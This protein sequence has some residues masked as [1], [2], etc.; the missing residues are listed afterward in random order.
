MG[1]AVQERGTP[2]V[3]QTKQ[4]SPPVPTEQEHLYPISGM[5]TQKHSLHH[6]KSCD[7]FPIMQK[8]LIFFLINCSNK[9][10]S[11]CGSDFVQLPQVEPFL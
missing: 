3:C 4:S 7:R 1:Q 10:S 9:F 11:V 5:E 2:A 6:M 8:E